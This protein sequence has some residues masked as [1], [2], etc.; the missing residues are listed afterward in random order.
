M[1]TTD[2]PIKMV[3]DK[4]IRYLRWSAKLAGIYF[5]GRFAA[6]II[7]NTVFALLFGSYLSLLPNILI[8]L[9]AGAFYL[10]MQSASQLP[11]VQKN[12]AVSTAFTIG[13]YGAIFWIV[14]GI[15]F[16]YAS[17]LSDSMASGGLLGSGQFQF[18]LWLLAL[19][20]AVCLGLFARMLYRKNLL[21]GMTYTY[22]NLGVVGITINWFT[23]LPST[24]YY[25]LAITF[26]LLIGIG[27]YLGALQIAAIFETGKDQPVASW[28]WL[29]R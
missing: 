15:I 1:T 4:T 7:S 27:W 26:F 6:V 19:A 25:M 24:A 28:Q 2:E 8:P 13:R 5:V 17:L 12:S 20:T 16:T 9:M 11:Q 23:V 21:T 14:L 29:D 10:A 22:L 18:I 3:Q